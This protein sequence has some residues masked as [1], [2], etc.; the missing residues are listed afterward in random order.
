MGKQVVHYQ[1]LFRVLSDRIQAGELVGKLP[2]I[3]EFVQEFGVSHNTVKKV[4]DQLKQAGKVY[5][6]QGKGVFVIPPTQPEQLGTCG[7]IGICI[8]YST[9]RNP[10]YLRLFEALRGELLK[11]R[12]V[13]R[14][15]LTVAQMAGTNLDGA[16]CIGQNFSDLEVQVLTSQ[17]GAHVVLLNSETQG[18]PQ[19]GC[20]N[21]ECGRMAA[22]YLYEHG[23]R[24]IGVISRDLN[25]KGCFFDYRWRGVRAFAAQ[26]TDLELT[27]V[28]VHIT[29]F[30]ADDVQARL[31]AT[32]LLDSAPDITAIF[33]F[34][35]VLA[36]GVLST[37][38]QRRIRVPED[39]SLVSVDN[40]DF[41]I[42]MNPPLTTLEE[43]AELIAHRALELV[44]ASHSSAQPAGQVMLPPKLVE[45]GSVC[46]CVG[47]ESPRRVYD[48][49]AW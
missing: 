46:N 14:Q 32:E 21:F 49:I 40:R 19:V 10:F 36:L 35:D 20:D 24:K 9:L 11:R 39:I 28:P 4:I 37:L 15:F 33:A 17:L 12:L 18:L 3:A 13:F 22:E 34:T 6:F 25:L 23:H 8:D 7:R 5:G 2:S 41:S 31:A 30:E 48:S 1:K 16:L 38:Q 43:P 29:K 26:H 45:R 44:L 47:R 27:E 42:M